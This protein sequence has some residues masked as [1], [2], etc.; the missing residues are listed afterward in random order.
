LKGGKINVH[1]LTPEQLGCTR[2][3]LDTLKVADAGASLN[4]IKRVFDGEK[5][6][7]LDIIALNAGAAIYVSGVADSLQAGIEK[8]RKV[9]AEGGA[10][11][12]LAKL[13]AVTAAF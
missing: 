2:S 7:A 10:K 8:A 12:K 4:L 1:T 9:I 5:G 6:P 3:K 11:A 13:I